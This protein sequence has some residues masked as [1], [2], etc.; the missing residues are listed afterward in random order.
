M[1]RQIKDLL[2]NDKNVDATALR[3]IISQMDALLAKADPLNCNSNERDFLEQIHK[4]LGALSADFSNT[5]GNLQNKA[6]QENNFE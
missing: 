1:E 5:I 4:E 2:R 3:G 6:E